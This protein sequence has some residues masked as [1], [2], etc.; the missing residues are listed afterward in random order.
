[1]SAERMM[2]LMDAS[3]ATGGAGLLLL[4]HTRLVLLDSSTVRS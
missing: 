1:M 4:P 3:A 2:T